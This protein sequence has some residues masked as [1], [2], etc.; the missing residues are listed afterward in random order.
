[1]DEVDGRWLCPSCH[2]EARRLFS[3]PYDHSENTFHPYYSDALSPTSEKTYVSSRA[4]E[5][6]QML[7]MGMARYE[8][9]MI[10]DNKRLREEQKA[11]VCKETMDRVREPTIRKL[12][13]AKNYGYAPTR[14][15]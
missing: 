6:R 3:S 7:A 12:Y 8:K 9:G 15:D 11:N 10:N 5:K 13:F 1:M 14:G 2:G 4:D